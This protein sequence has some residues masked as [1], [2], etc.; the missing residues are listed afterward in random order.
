MKSDKSLKNEIKSFQNLWGKGTGHAQRTWGETNNGTLLQDF[1]KIAEICIYPYINSLIT[2]LEI[3][4]N[5][6]LWTQKMIHAKK[7]YCLEAVSA[8]HTG[9]W[10]NIGESE[11]IQYIQVNDYDGSA[12]NGRWFFMVQNYFVNY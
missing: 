9:F 6:G 11:K 10:E 12:V 4:S 8:N 1:N 2:V 7:I 5:A 3:G